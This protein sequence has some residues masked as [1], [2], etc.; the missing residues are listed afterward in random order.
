MSELSKNKDKE[1]YCCKHK[2]GGQAGGAVYG[3]GFIGGIIFFVQNSTS[4]TDALLGVV[5]AIFW[6]AFFVYKFFEYIQ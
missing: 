3:I 1:Y 5:K 6:P 2:G 4:I